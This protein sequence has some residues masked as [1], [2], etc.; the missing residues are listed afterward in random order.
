MTRL[1]NLKKPKK[2]SVKEFLLKRKEVLIFRGMGGLGDL[3]MHRMMFEDFKLINPDIRL[4][5]ACPPQYKDALIDHPFL[6]EVRNCKETFLDDYLIWF[7]TTHACG[8]Y[9]IS[10]APFADKHRSDIWAEHCG[11][12]LTKHNMHINLT[13]EEKKRGIEYIEKIRINNGPSVVLCPKS[14]MAS[15]NLL[16]NQIKDLT[17]AVLDMNY[18]IFGLHHSPIK[19]LNDLKIPC[20]YDVKIRDWMSII[21]AADY[22]ISVDTSAFH[23]AGG[24]GKPLTGIFTWAD[25]KVYGKYFDFF[26]VQKHRDNGDWGC[27]PCYNYGICPLTKNQIKPCLTNITS[28]MIINSVIKMFIKWPK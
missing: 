25:G 3:L 20:I 28:E 19:E 1:I 6:D 13:D 24:I 21:W 7:N 22:V 12:K 27:G 9:E 10:K 5:C 15:K 17:K 23:F 14:A 11:V 8:R 18:F 16:P 4:V 26:L 2:W